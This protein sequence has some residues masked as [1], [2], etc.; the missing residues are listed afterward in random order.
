MENCSD[1]VI[2]NVLPQLHLSLYGKS[3]ASAQAAMK[4]YIDSFEEAIQE[5][6]TGEA[7]QSTLRFGRPFCL[8]CF[9]PSCLVV[10]IALPDIRFRQHIWADDDYVQ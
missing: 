9:F 2:D 3:L 7:R 5:R 6:L 10:H 8:S 1:F 4:S